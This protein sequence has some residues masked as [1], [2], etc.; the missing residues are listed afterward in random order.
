VPNKWKR[1]KES[2]LSEALTENQEIGRRKVKQ[3]QKKT[4]KKQKTPKKKKPT[5]PHKATG[6]EIKIRPSRT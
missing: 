5:H 6:S 3:P 1:E 4:T 2:T